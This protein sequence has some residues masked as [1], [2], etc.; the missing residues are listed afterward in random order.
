MI[1]PVGGELPPLDSEPSRPADPG[2][3]SKAKGTARPPA[4]KVARRFRQ[5][6]D[7]VDVTLRDLTHAERSVWLILFRDM[8]DGTARTAQTDLARRAGFSVATVQRALRRLESRGLVRVV[9]PGRLRGGPS[10][11]ALATGP[12]Q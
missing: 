9:R 1:I 11:Y 10:V 12:N 4:A 7:F 3:R 5:L 6:N 8:R 2:D